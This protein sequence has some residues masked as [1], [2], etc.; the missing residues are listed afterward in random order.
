MPNHDVTDTFE[1]KRWESW[2][3]PDVP[4]IQGRLAQIALVLLGLEAIIGIWLRFSTT[5]LLWLDEA[6]TVNIAR[7]P[8]HDLRGALRRDGAPPLYYVLLH[9]WMKIFGQ[10]DFAVRSLSGVFS[11]LTVVACYFL[12]RRL[13]GREFGLIAVAILLAMPFATYYATESRQYALVMLIVA[14]GGIALARLFERPTLWPS[15]PT[16]RCSAGRP[17]ACGPACSTAAS[18]PARGLISR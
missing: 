5:S 17:V 8:L 15:T 3:A 4:E 9:F 16:R 7:L 18:K 13:W 6:L 11:V 14:L 12:A 10:S 1:E 2:S